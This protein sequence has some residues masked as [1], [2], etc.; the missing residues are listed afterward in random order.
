M[1]APITAIKLIMNKKAVLTQLT[2]WNG[3]LSA[4]EKTVLDF[5][6]FQ[7]VT[8]NKSKRTDIKLTLAEET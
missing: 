6:G 7:R 4:M 1:G 2:R 8:L 3:M 5:F